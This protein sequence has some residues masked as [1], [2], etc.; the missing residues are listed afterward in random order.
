MIQR[1]GHSEGESTP[2]EQSTFIDVD[3]WQCGRRVVNVGDQVRCKPLVGRPFK[4]VVTRIRAN[5]DTEL[6]FEI[7]VVGGKP[8][9]KSVRTFN[10]DRVKPM[11]KRRVSAAKV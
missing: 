4:A 6:V 11:P 9:M 2:P 1:S 7:E 5:I 10:T 8:G 3:Q